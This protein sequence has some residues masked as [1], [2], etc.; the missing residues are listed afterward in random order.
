MPAVWLRRPSISAFPS[1]EKPLHY[2]ATSIPFKLLSG[3]V[4]LNSNIS[5][6]RKVAVSHR[7][8][9]AARPP[10]ASE[11]TGYCLLKIIAILY[12]TFY[13]PIEVSWRHSSRFAERNRHV[14]RPTCVPR[15]HLMYADVLSSRFNFTPP[16]IRP[17]G[18]V[19]TCVLSQSRP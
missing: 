18:S 17:I 16:K 11:R 3:M 2:L 1:G 9:C 7:Q 10:L 19:E 15:D 5:K 13:F 6:R 8:Q 12:G 14:I 4:V